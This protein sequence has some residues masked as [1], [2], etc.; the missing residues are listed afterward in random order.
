M[1]LTNRQSDPRS[2]ERGSI[3][4]MAV[5]FMSLLFLMVGMCI[6]VS[7][8][9]MARA[10]VQNAADAAAL[11][12]ARELDR[13]AGGIDDAVTQA[14]AIVNTHGFGKAGVSIAS[15]EFAVSLNGTYMNAATAKDPATA[16]NIRFVRV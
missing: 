16:P 8:I 12:A 7:R 14:N 6:D 2:D 13:G 1:S 4:I 11:T 10:E 9:Y 15:V 3:M 5:I